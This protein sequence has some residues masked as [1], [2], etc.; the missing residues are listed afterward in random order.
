MPEAPD[1]IAAGSRPGAARRSVAAIVWVL[2][3]LVGGAAA[4]VVYNFVREQA[5]QR[6]AAVAA[7]GGDIDAGSQALRDFGCG[8]CHIIPGIPGAGGRVGPDLTGL[9]RRV[10]V[11]GVIPNTP[12]NL[13]RF[14]VNPR[15]VD[16]M[17]AMPQTGITPDQARDVAAYLYSL[18]Y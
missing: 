17:S 16:P 2:V 14:I 3:L 5:E 6:Q 9:V 18:R 13:V 10:Y 12:D 15:S 4:S 7:T 1:E 8:G 11:A